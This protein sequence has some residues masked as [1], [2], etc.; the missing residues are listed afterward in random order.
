MNRGLNTYTYIPPPEREGG[1]TQMFRLVLIDVGALLFVLFQ[2]E[3]KSFWLQSIGCSGSTIRFSTYPRNKVIQES[4]LV[5]GICFGSF[6]N[7]AIAS[8]FNTQERHVYLQ[9]TTLTGM[10]TFA[11]E[12][13]R[14][15]KTAKA[16]CVNRTDKLRRP[17]INAA[18]SC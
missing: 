6:P 16:K 14:P 7:L 2:L 17:L 3:R 8:L 10:M 9:S 12:A 18:T 4:C 11:Q 5:V 1:K 13:D 15:A